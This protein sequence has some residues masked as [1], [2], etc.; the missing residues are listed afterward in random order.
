MPVSETEFRASLARF[1]S[2]VTVVTAVDPAGNQKGI[3]V[4]SFASLSL[5]PPLVMIA[6]GRGAETHGALTSTGRF[7]VNILEESQEEMSRR[8]A[9][10]S[11]GEDQFEG[12]VT[13]PGKGG[14]PLLADSLATLE[15]R[16]V[17]RY[18]GGDHT[19][20]VGEVDAVTTH[21]GMPLLYFRGRYRRMHRDHET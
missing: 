9:T 5:S 18:E 17:H 12:V 2:G 21:D 1:A 10:P 6:V 3:T 16:I 15:C 8:F 14:L 19:I 4:S 13:Q 20:F 7:A 11:S